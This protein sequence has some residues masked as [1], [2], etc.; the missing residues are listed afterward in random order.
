MLAK[1]PISGQKLMRQDVSPRLRVIHHVR[2]RGTMSTI[3]ERRSLGTQPSV[4]GGNGNG[5]ARTAR[6]Y[7]GEASEAFFIGFFC[8]GDGDVRRRP[9]AVAVAVAGLGFETYRSE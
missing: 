4:S 6:I 1:D 2:S 9:V 7:R 8:G 5:K 3:T